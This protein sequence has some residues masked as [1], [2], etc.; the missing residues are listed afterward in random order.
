M[1]Q[2][3]YR[4]WEVLAK[5]ALRPGYC[6]VNKPV[7]RRIKFAGFIEKSVQIEQQPM[8]QHLTPEFQPDVMA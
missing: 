1:A 5:L 6:G 8:A 3:R 7:K 4:Q 2:T